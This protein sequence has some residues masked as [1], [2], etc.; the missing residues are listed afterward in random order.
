[1]K[2]RICL[3]ETP[4]DRSTDAMLPYVAPENAFKSILTAG[5]P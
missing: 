4:D 2:K 3:P 5:K 1:M